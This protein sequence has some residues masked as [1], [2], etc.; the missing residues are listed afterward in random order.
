MQSYLWKI[1]TFDLSDQIKFTKKEIERYIH[2]CFKKKK[3]MR[4]N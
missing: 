4:G 3:K 1:I 2:M